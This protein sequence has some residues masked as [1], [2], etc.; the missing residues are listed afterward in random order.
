MINAMKA[1]IAM[2]NPD[3]QTAVASKLRLCTTPN[4]FI[5]AL[6]EAKSIEHCV[7]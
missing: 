6:K 7:R 5:P 1:I 3:M 2:H 4:T